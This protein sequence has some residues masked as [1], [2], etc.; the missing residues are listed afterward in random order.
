MFVSL[1]LPA[2]KKLRQS[3]TNVQWKHC[4]TSNALNVPYNEEITEF[5]LDQ[6]SDP[7]EFF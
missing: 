7:I 2:R 3:Q 4:Q 1:D 5:N 6:F